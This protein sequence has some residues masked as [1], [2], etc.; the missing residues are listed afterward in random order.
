MQH[1]T[2]SLSILI[3]L[4]VITSCTN[5]KKVNQNNDIML[6]TIE[7]ET[8]VNKGGKEISTIKDLYFNVQNGDTYFIKFMSSNMTYDEA[9]A[10]LG[11]KI[12]VEAKIIDGLWDV[13]DDNPQYAQSR[14]G[15]YIVIKSFTPIIKKK[16]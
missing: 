14:T 4:M 12:S 7:E 10:N 13:A 9:K 5:T 8:F 6:G 3:I 11:K 1:K 15:P 2:L 16:D